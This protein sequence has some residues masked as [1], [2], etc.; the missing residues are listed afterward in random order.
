MPM[1][2]G[3]PGV[4][5]LLPWLAAKPNFCWHIPQET[6]NLR[7]YA[8]ACKINCHLVLSKLAIE[9]G[10]DLLWQRLR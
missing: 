1:A 8:N 6:K 4:L 10:E 3:M 2:S 9:S 5:A 7:K